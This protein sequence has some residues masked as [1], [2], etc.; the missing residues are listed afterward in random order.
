[1]MS[2]TSDALTLSPLA[3]VSLMHMASSP[4]G[5]RVRSRC[6]RARC[7]RR[8]RHAWLEPGGA[9]DL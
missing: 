2:T 9:L 3:R 8:R 4:P 5:K 6:T 7:Y 1:M